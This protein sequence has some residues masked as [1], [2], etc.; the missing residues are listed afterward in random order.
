MVNLT[1]VYTAERTIRQVSGGIYE[2]HFYMLWGALNLTV[3]YN[4]I[5]GTVSLSRLVSDYDLEPV[6]VF[7]IENVIA[8]HLTNQK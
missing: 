8:N 6:E 5:T 2:S 4:N 7:A 1:D 3:A